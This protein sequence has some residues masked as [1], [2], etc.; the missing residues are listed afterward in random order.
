M[1]EAEKE[2]A[3][4]KTNNNVLAKDKMYKKY[5]YIVNDVCENNDKIITREEALNV[6]KRFIDDCVA[7]D[8]KIKDDIEKYIYLRFMSYV[9]K[10]I[11]FNGARVDIRTLVAKAQK[12]D[13]EARNKLVEHYSC[14]V[15]EKAKEYDYLEYEE[16]LQYGMIRLIEVIDLVLTHKNA[17]L[18]L[19]AHCTRAINSL[20]SCRLKNEVSR[21]DKKF[22][23]YKVVTDP[24]DHSLDDK[25]FELELRS[26]LAGTMST[27][28]CQDRFMK[29]YYDSLT[30]ADIGDEHG[31]VTRQA[32]HCSKTKCLKLLKNKFY[33]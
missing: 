18:L 23:T 26:T 25:M 20:F 1:K 3:I 13:I 5:L 6:Y 29:H 14:I 28:L 2:R 19:A 10:K 8:G 11:S 7:A 30:L 32:V 16:L 12:G 9:Y 17:P 15:L 24:F 4:E 33:K 27:E 31:G 21:D 22:Y